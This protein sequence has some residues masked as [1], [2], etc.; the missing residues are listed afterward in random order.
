MRIKIIVVLSFF[1]VLF[2]LSD[3]LSAESV[4]TEEQPPQEIQSAPVEPPVPAPLEAASSVSQKSEKSQID[5]FQD[6]VTAVPMAEGKV[7]V[8]SRGATLLNVVHSLSQLTGINCIAGKE[9]AERRLNMVL[10]KV[11]LEDALDAISRG[12]NVIYD[13]YPDRNLYV[14]RGSVITEDQ[15]S[16]I[17]KVFKLYYILVSEPE[18]L[19]K[20]EITGGGSSGKSLLSTIEHTRVDEMPLF[21]IVKNIL[22][23]RGKLQVDNRS[24]SLVI[25][26]T[27]ERLKMIE[28]AIVSLDQPVEQIYME[29][30][31]V[32]TLSALEDYFGIEWT[33]STTQGTWGI[34]TG[35]TS[36]ER[37]PFNIKGPQF[38]GKDEWFG[39]KTETAVSNTYTPGSL[40]FTN[41]TAT[42]KALQVASKLK[43]IAKPKVL[44]RDN[45]YALIAVAN[46]ETIGEQN[47]TVT[48]GTQATS[49]AT[50]AERQLTGTL[51][52]VIPMINTE[53][54]ITLH[55][56]V[57]HITTAVSDLVSTRKDPTARNVVTDLMVNNGQTVCFGGMIVSSQTNAQHKVPGLG[58]IPVI[59]RAFKRGTK[60][61]NDRELVVFITPHIIKDPSDLR[62]VSVPDKKERQEDV[63]APIWKVK[64]KEWYKNL[65]KEKN[66]EL[67][68]QEGNTKERDLLMDLAAQEIEAGLQQ[69]ESALGPDSI[70]ESD[71]RPI[72][73]NAKAGTVTR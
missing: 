27:E 44:V 14:F 18:R 16:L 36:T 11:T 24:N 72:V 31:I 73:I 23:D 7:G 35:G 13:F 68:G 70:I 42:L 26:D 39:T 10:D 57:A 69:P 4:L 15:P 17:T 25:T 65:T 71:G 56:E 9:V 28:E 41:L 50:T 46:S 1:L 6:E 67:A 54:R 29:A 55:V 63:S 47:V 61:M 19:D 53:N 8:E 58:D 37:F 45:N 30:V 22:S 2:C 21:K 62:V 34:L 52:Y 48:V 20:F 43:I 3:S 12:A 33:K 5:S 38:L 40:S 32:E 66:Q 64:K 51:L 59:G 60:Q 49:Q